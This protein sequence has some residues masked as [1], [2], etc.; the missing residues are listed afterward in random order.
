[1]TQ[2]LEQP[3][4]VRGDAF[5][6]SPAFR[7][8]IL[9][10][11]TE[12]LTKGSPAGEVSFIVSVFGAKDTG[13]AHGNTEL[14][15]IDRGAFQPWIARTNFLE[16]P[17]GIYL[18]HGDAPVYG[19][20]RS[21]KLLGQ[22]HHVS[23]TAEGLRVDGRYNLR[24]EVSR[25]AFA[26]LQEF[27]NLVQ[28]SFSNYRDEIKYR[29]E[30]GVQHVKEYPTGAIEFS[31]VG[32]G[33]QGGTRLLSTRAEE[34]VARA[35]NLDDLPSAIRDAWYTAHS[36]GDMMD[37]PYIC[38]VYASND[39]QTKGYAIT[40]NGDGYQQVSW[41]KD[42]NGVVA[43][44]ESNPADVE[45]SWVYAGTTKVLRNALMVPEA[46]L[47][48][49]LIQMRNPGILGRLRTAVEEA[50]RPNPASAFYEALLTQ[51]FTE[52]TISP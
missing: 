37:A 14:E 47:V 13:V 30:S 26:D 22:A 50:S 9:D 51:E 6:V 10:M 20:L 52:S 8:S 17:N 18:D 2:V 11:D 43:F 25:D 39:T 3:T 21:E 7:T 34:M 16:D 42:S 31:Q 49:A 32:R 29:D 12:A 15:V 38:E 23:E 33:A 19:Y 27:P 24:K 1:M 46:T 45:K 4:A 5:V 36:G 48:E 40:R 41:S 44:D 28:F 35:V